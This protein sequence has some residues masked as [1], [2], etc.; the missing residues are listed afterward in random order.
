MAWITPVTDRTANAR[1][2][3]DNTMLNRIEGNCQYLSVQ[4]NSYGYF[5]SITVKTDWAEDDFPYQDEMDRIKGNVNAI[6]AAYHTLIGSP[7]IDFDT[8]MNWDDAND[9]EQNIKNIDTLLQR[10]VAGFRYCGTFNCGQ[11]AILP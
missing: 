6:L 5:V 9:L 2:K 4:L 3:L 7:S 1:G 11:E 10:M 8:S